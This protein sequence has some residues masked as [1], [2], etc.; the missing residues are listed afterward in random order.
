M[1]GLLFRGTTP[2]HRPE[3]TNAYDFEGWVRKWL[4]TLAIG[5]ES[6]SL[7]PISAFLVGHGA[8]SAPTSR[9]E[10]RKKSTRKFTAILMTVP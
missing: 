7:S 10:H 1:R 2:V 6:R 8:G 5:K 4:A 3:N 9:L